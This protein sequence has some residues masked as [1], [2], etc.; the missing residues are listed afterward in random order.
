MTRTL[1]KS[2]LPLMLALVLGL[3]ISGSAWAGHGM[4]PDMGGG[5]GMMGPGMKGHG[6]GWMNLT[7]D[8][9]GKAFDQ[10]QKFMTDT[11]D[12]RKQML[13]KQAEL[14]DLWKAKEPDKAKIEA[15]Q[16]ELNTVRDQ[17]QAKGTTFKLEMK[18]QF[19]NLGDGPGCGMMGGGK[20]MAGCPMMAGDKG[21]AGCPMMGGGKGMA[22]CP[23]TP[24]PAEGA[25]K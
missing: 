18:K 23:M 6:M 21:M 25:K 24:A 7:P 16:K 20:G 8:E 9:I 2:W 10:R 4:G 1:R 15:K 19:P 13:V 17:L 14:R 11:A 3:G 12:L 5:C 22:N